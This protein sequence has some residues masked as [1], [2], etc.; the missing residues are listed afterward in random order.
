MGKILDELRQEYAAE[1]ANRKW[2]QR[3]PK[4][5]S[6]LYM[7]AR[8]RDAEREKRETEKL[9]YATEE[10]AIDIIGRFDADGSLVREFKQKIEVFRE[11]L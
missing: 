11:H 8:M 5:N 1:G 2:W 6:I 10:A 7:G 9:A 4:G 3:A